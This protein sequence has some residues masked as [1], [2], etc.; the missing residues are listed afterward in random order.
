MQHGITSLQEFRKQDPM[1][2]EMLLNRRPP[3]GHQVLAIVNQF[4]QYYIEVEEIGTTHSDGSS[5]VEVELAVTCGLL[6]DSDTGAGLPKKSKSKYKDMTQILTVSSDLDYVDFRRTPTKG[7]K[8]PKTFVITAQ[9]TK[10]SQSV[11]VQVSSETIAGIT[12]TQSYKPNIPS[13]AYPTVI[14][15]PQNA[16]VDS[17]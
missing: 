16:Q 14:T 10:P 8:T 3:F 6:D 5:P 11:L 1:R 4:P 15:R 7:L 9:L 2:L 17:L 12:I 13:T